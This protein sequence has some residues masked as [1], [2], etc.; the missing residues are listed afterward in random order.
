MW[1]KEA[2]TERVLGQITTPSDLFPQGRPR[3]LKSSEIPKIVPLIGNQV[4]KPFWRE[5]FISKLYYSNPGPQ[6]T[7]AHLT[8]LNV[9]S[10]LVRV[11]IILTVPPL[12]KIPSSKIPL[13]LKAD[14]NL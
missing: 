6:K 7:H 8:M 9:F 2:E 11:S 13:R 4:H 5:H 3:L 10:P 1:E 12:F 14:S